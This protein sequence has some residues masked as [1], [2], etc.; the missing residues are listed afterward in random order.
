M[1]GRTAFTAIRP[2]NLASKLLLIFGT[3]I[4]VH[5][6]NYFIHIWYLQNNLLTYFSW[7]SS[8]TVA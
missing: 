5:L 1:D 8:S 7:L 3:D 2:S 4:S 6:L